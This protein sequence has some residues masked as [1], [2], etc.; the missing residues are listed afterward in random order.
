MT[1]IR[2]MGAGEGPPEGGPHASAR[3]FHASAASTRTRA[4]VTIYLGGAASNDDGRHRVHNDAASRGGT[5]LRA[6]QSKVA[7][8]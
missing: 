7:Q 4:H 1:P 6:W 3:Q 8:A 5:W 2:V